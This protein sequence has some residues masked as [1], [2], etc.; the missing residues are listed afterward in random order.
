LHKIKLHVIIPVCKSW[1]F[2][3][4]STHTSYYIYI[5]TYSG[6]GPR[7]EFTS[8]LFNVDSWQTYILCVLLQT[9][10]A[11]QLRFNSKKARQTNHDPNDPLLWH[12]YQKKKLCGVISSNKLTSENSKNVC[13]CLKIGAPMKNPWVLA[14][15][16]PHM[17][18]V[19]FTSV[20]PRLSWVLNCACIF[21]SVLFFYSP[22]RHFLL[23]ACDFD[24]V[25]LG[26]RVKT[27]THASTCGH[28]VAF[29]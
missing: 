20:F 12:N 10:V 13:S 16:L 28:V 21:C 4:V 24:R 9:F 11:I 19:P 3:N 22:F 2:A 17:W 23:F 26:A 29:N 27:S 25:C 6:P 1:A 5:V 15:S 7:V 18:Q 8:R 14:R